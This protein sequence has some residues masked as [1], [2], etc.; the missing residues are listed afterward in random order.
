MPKIKTNRSAAK[1][2]KISK[3]GK[4]IRTK[5]FK[6]HQLTCKSRKKKRQARGNFVVDPGDAKRIMRLISS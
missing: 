2:F 6:R 3:S 1:R 4:V 5:A